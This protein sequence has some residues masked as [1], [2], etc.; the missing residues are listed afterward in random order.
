MKKCRP[1][2]AAA[3]TK[4][5]PKPAPSFASACDVPPSQRGAERN[6]FQPVSEHVLFGATPSFA[7]A[8]SQQV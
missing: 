7:A 5:A 6:A 1:P 3:G 4:L 8:A 2:P